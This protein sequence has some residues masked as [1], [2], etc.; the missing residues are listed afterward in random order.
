MRY[1]LDTHVLLWFLFNS[2]ELS[3]EN[4]ELITN[5]ENQLYYS[6]SSLWEIETKHCKFPNRFPFTAK[7]IASAADKSQI[8]NIPIF[9][10]DI[11]EYS[12]SIK[13]TSN[14]NHNDP[15]DVILLSQAKASDLILLTADKKFSYYKSK[16]IKII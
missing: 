15:F 6:T 2:P 11:Y 10:K 16:N 14:K 7:E 1:L 8:V 9:N 12:N 13:I 5:P 4:K 3:K